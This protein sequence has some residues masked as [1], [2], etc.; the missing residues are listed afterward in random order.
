ME[1][2]YF[3]ESIEC[4]RKTRGGRRIRNVVEDG[5]VAKRRVV[6]GGDGASGGVVVVGIFEVGIVGLGLVFVLFLFCGRIALNKRQ[7]HCVWLEWTNEPYSSIAV[8]L[9]SQFSPNSI[10]QPWTWLCDCLG[11]GTRWFIYFLV[12]LQGQ[13]FF[14]FSSVFSF[15]WVKLEYLSKLSLVSSVKFNELIQMIISL[16]I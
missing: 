11:F 15:C 16:P 7:A 10:H 12:T 2:S 5:S 13:I 3:G 14:F 8:T 4:R 9:Q 1:V 6:C